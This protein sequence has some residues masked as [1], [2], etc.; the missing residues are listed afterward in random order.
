MKANRQAY[1][2][3]IVELG[4]KY[5]NLF[6]LDADLGAATGISKF[7]D[8]IP[9]RYIECGIAEQNMM[10]IAA[11][12]ASCGKIPFPTSFA[13]FISM[14]AIEQV[15]NSICYPNFNVK[16]VATHAGIEVGPDG[17]THQSVEDVAIMRSLPNMSVFVPA[18]PVATKK[19]HT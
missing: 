12:L 7:K 13:V 17:A 16:V 14:R 9:E 6:V 18:D 8:T 5:N 1:G 4:Y 19:L 2:E 3:A 15:R 11:G 10:G